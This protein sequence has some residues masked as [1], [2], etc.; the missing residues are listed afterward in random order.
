M[1]YAAQTYDFEYN[2]KPTSS[3]SKKFKS[4]NVKE[5]L[6]SIKGQKVLLLAKK[7]GFTVRGVTELIFLIWP[8]FDTDDELSSIVGNLLRQLKG[9][10]GLNVILKVLKLVPDKL[11]KK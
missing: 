8:L 10:D 7:L 5:F 1:P 4:K 2:E 3:K 11:N 9:V 6:K